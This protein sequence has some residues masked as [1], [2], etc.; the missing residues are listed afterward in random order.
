MS[1]GAARMLKF[2]KK[3]TFWSFVK[4]FS[5]KIIFGFLICTRLEKLPYGVDKINLKYDK[6]WNAPWGAARTLKFYKNP[7]FK[8]FERFFACLDYEIKSFK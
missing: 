5:K 7:L 1:W 3:H 8:L 4:E 2:H 6:Y